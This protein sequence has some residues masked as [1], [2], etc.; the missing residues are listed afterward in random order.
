[1]VRPH[2]HAGLEF[3]GIELDPVANA[4]SARLIGATGCRVAVL[5]VPTDEEL[6]IALQTLATVSG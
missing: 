3:L 1:V 6:E 5:V 4:E 2:F